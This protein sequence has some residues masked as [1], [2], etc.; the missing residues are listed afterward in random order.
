MKAGIQGWNN[1]QWSRSVKMTMNPKGQLN[2]GVWPQ[3]GLLHYVDKT[4]ITDNIIL[5]LED[6]VCQ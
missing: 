6:L 5:S 4:A 1:E 3:Q 2:I